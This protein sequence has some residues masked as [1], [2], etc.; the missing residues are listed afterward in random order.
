MTQAETYARR[1]HEFLLDLAGAKL[2]KA[3]FRK[4]SDTTTTIMPKISLDARLPSPSIITCNTKIPLRLLVKR[5]ND[6]DEFLY[7]QSIQIELIGH[8]RIRAHQ[9]FRQ[10][11]NG[12]IIVSRSNMNVLLHRPTDTSPATSSKAS[13][14]PISLEE[15]EIDPTLWAAPLPASIA[16]TFQSCNIKRTYDLELRIGIGWGTNATR[17]AAILP[18]RLPVSVYSGIRPP[19][20]LATQAVVPPPK[21]PR[22]P[23]PAAAAASSSSAGPSYAPLPPGAEESDE[24]PPTYEDAVGQDLAPVDG[25]RNYRPPAMEGG[26]GFESE[27]KRRGS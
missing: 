8:T 11:T 3:F 26:G 19:P 22:K 12:Y 14:P 4:A 25:P 16:P 5:L 24:P 13:I 23:V 20:G 1:Q 2:K 15:I 6:S 10:E 18:L 9:A 27:G 17:N 21:P 7:L